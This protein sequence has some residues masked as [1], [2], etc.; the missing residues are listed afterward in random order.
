[1]SP[2]SPLRFVYADSHPNS[3]IVSGPESAVAVE[4][5]HAG[6]ILSKEEK[7]NLDSKHNFHNKKQ[8]DVKCE[9][10]KKKKKC[11]KLGKC[12]WNQKT[13]KCRNE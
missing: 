13:K 12:V 10:I 3:S 11:E 7:K 1:M 6:P 8:V 4:T 5:L 9:N 2:R